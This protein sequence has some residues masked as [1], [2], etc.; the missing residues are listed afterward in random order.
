MIGDR[1]EGAC[2]VNIELRIW[3]KKSLVE[4]NNKRTKYMLIAYSFPVLIS[5]IYFFY[6]QKFGFFF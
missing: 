4:F 3:R 2:D 5:R 6:N 1:S